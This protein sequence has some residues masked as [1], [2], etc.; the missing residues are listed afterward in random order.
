L[1]SGL[2][3]L[4][5]FLSAS[6]LGNQ[7]RV[8]EGT[9]VQSVIIIYDS[10]KGTTFINA[11]VLEGERFHQIVIH[12]EFDTGSE[13]SVVSF[14]ITFATD[15][16]CKTFTIDKGDNPG[17][18][19]GRRIL[20]QSGKIDGFDPIEIQGIRSYPL[21]STAPDPKEKT[22]FLVR[23]TLNY[24]RGICQMIYLTLGINCR[25]MKK[26]IIDDIAG[27]GDPF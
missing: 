15:K 21:I 4:F 27:K 24:E 9:I 1:S 25:N 22:P 5:F 13:I 23:V 18:V 12:I 10:A 16:A 20:D 11:A 8:V 26:R 6:A 3:G 7:F 17:A 19:S 2:P 14:K